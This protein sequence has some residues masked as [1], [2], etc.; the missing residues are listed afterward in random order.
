MNVQQVCDEAIGSVEGGLSC[1]LIDLQRDRV[2]A[3]E[4]RP[5]AAVS[6]DEVEQLIRLCRDMFRGQLIGIYAESLSTQEELPGEFV[7]EA[8]VTTASGCHFF[9]AIPGWE[10]AAMILMI[11]SS[12][13]LG[14]SWIA[15]RQAREKL[16]QFQPSEVQVALV[17][18]LG[19]AWQ[20][21]L[22][23][24]PTARARAPAASKP[25]PALVATH[26]SRPAAWDP[27]EA[28]AQP[29][30]DA[31]LSTKHR[32]EAPDEPTPAVRFGARAQVYRAR[33]RD[34]ENRSREEKNRPRTE[35]RSQG[36][37]NVKLARGRW[38]RT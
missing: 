6:R 15:I 23:R 34:K 36:R 12:K 25:E 4:K 21:A 11:E 2:L 38:P 20:R 1:L 3:F 22:E 9:A 16:M 30:R 32:S 35:E 29:T 33:V 28:N 17:S 19:E 7:Q 8:Q 31:L 26:E 24:P 5:D 13:N 27:R 10:A 37:A 14:L 18:D